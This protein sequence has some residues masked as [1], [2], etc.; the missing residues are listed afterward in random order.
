MLNPKKCMGHPKTV[1]KPGEVGTVW[2]YSPLR[3][4]IRIIKGHSNEYYKKNE[5]NL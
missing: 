5:E 4:V 1:C 2:A 3:K